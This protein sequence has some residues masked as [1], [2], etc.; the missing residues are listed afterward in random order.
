MRLGKI[1]CS[2][3]VKFNTGDFESIVIDWSEEHVLEKG[4]D[5]DECRKKVQAL[6]TRGFMAQLRREI[7]DVAL[8]RREERDEETKH[9]MKEIRAYANRGRS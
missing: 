9:R 2:R 1:R 7:K 4:D 3:T 5:E 6:V 8:R